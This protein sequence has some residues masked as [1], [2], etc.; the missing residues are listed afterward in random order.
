MTLMVKM[1]KSYGSFIAVCAILL[2][3][4]CTS[5]ER[6]K[7]TIDTSSS[8]PG[9]TVKLNGEVKQLA[10]TPITVGNPLPETYLI[11][12]FSLRSVDISQ[13]KGKVL[14][15]SLVPS[16]ENVVRMSFFDARQPSLANRLYDAQTQYLGQQ[17]REL[18][19]DVVRI[20]ISRDTP[21]EQKRFAKGAQ[22]TDIM[23]LSDFR[24]GVF[25]RS[26][27]LLVKD[28]RYLAR[29]VI[30]VDK[31]GIVR[32]IQVVPE[33]T[34]LPDMERAVAIANELAGAT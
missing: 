9:M 12:A 6:I 17:G 25:G 8:M 31:D 34:H 4:G 30:L 20:A 22:L 23:Y 16:L 2:L 18:S 14:F 24:A 15:L 5:M 29:A 21:Y 28:R 27:G 7:Y 13:M 11:D 32:Y 3:P 33:L 19:S 1:M 10:G 26:T